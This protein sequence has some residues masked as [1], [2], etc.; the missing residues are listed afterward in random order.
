MLFN[1]DIFLQFFAAFLLLYWLVRHHLAARNLLLVVASYFFYGW[2]DWR[3]LSLLLVSSLLDYGVGRALA[4]TEHP[5]RRQLWLALSLTANLTILGVFKYYGFF[6]DSLAALLERAGIPFHPG[7]LH[8]LLPVG[9][10]FYTFQTMSYAID[11]Y[12]RELPATRNL[13]NFLAYVAFFP[14][15]VAGPI[16]RG[17]HL[18]PQFERTLH[19]SAAM[20]REGAWLIL[21][22]MTKKVVFAD[23]LA[24]LVE[25]VYDGPAN[26]GP[27][28]VLGTVAF[29]LQI[30][31]DFSGYSDIARGLAR[32]LGFDLM[33]NFHLPY[34]ATSP[35]EFWQRWHI[36]L[37]TWLRDY[38]YVSLGGNRRGKVRT[39]VNLLTTMLLG[40]LWHGAAWNFVL[41]GAWHGGGLV[42][43]RALG[44]GDPATA[45]RM[46][47]ALGWAATLGLVLY[48][49]LLFRARSFAHIAEL[50]GA[51][52]NWSAPPWLTGYLINLLVFGLP[53]VLMDL[54]QQRTRN[55][56]APL[57]LPWWGR[58]CLQATLLLAILLYWEKKQVPFI[59]FQF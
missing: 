15:L 53:M 30:Y 36:S 35:R 4:G 12:R 8:V 16:E 19:L 40:G 9:I 58:A 52:G 55:P 20:L 32:V 33:V 5:R 29:A 26:S 1:S 57:D 17:K 34:L 6:V 49:W 42:T 14:Q 43:H 27:A 54:W 11:V 51:L 18:L 56:L 21:W 46:R 28:V 47:A 44:A 48:G 31:G 39:Y 50:T 45:S 23:N 38:L 25:M 3:Y 59:Y 37:S 24:P 10:S 22:G 41:W 2:W 13:I 7:T